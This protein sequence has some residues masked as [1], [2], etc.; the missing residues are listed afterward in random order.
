MYLHI[1][2]VTQNKTVGVEIFKNI[3]KLINYA[4]SEEKMINVGI[5]R[6]ESVDLILKQNIFKKEKV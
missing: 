3:H 2:Q 1:H 6:L 4:I 5:G